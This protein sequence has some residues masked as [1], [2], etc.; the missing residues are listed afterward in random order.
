[1]NIFVGNLSLDVTV[2]ELCG[3]FESF[4]SVASAKIVM[5]RFTNRSRGF[6][7]IEMDREADG[8]LA[9]AALDGT[10]YRGKPLRVNEA[11]VQSDAMNPAGM[12]SPT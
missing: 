10:A 1:M 7:F 5:D 11:R 4:G 3:L 6:G 12:S 9:I 8:R 2:D